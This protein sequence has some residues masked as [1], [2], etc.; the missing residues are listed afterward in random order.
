[1]HF[2]MLFQKFGFL[3]LPLHG[4]SVDF[5]GE[6]VIDRIPFGTDKRDHQYWFH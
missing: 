2:W 6:D 4:N 1:M 5:D 3:G